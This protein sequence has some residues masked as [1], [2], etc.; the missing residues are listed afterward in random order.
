MHLNSAL[1]FTKYAKQ[2]F[3]SHTKVLEIGP[4]GDPSYYFALADV[5]DV[6]W[7]TLDL[8]SE[9]TRRDGDPS[10]TVAK[11]EYDY[12]LEDDFFDIVLAGQV[13]Y[14]VRDL[15]RWL[16]E[17]K[18]IVKPGGHIVLI[19]PVSWDH[20]PAPVDCWRIYPE[21]MATLMKGIPLEI[22]LYR[23]ESLEKEHIPSTS[24]TVPGNSSIDLNGNSRVRS[25]V[26]L[27]AILSR[28]PGLRRFTAPITV[29]YGTICICQK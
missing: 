24:L 5:E 7:Y 4:R 10:H 28:L 29:A 16:E 22:K 20:C 25:R 13:M 9:N 19:T 14:T 26:L 6:Q 12:P 18:R 11:S 27:N 1:L 2:Y 3:E 21:G 17:L 15:A 23:F 8:D